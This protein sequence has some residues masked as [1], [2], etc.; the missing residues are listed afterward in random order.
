MNK[1]LLDTDILSELIKRRNT[2]VDQQA[3]SYLHVHQRLS[4]SVVTY[5]EIVR[6]FRWKQAPAQIS[7][8]EYLAGESIVIPID[9]SIA[10][11]ASELW[12]IA[13]REGYPCGDADLLIAATAIVHQLRLVT[14][15]TAHYSWIT[16][17]ETDNWRV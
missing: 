1:V 9:T 11:K 14:G 6:G 10:S 17:L 2:S 16:E 12:S 13:R 7:K 4:F 5:F 15:N 3:A 8:F